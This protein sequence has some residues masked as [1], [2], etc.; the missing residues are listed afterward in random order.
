[1][2]HPDDNSAL[3]ILESGDRVPS[4]FAD[5]C[6]GGVDP[7]TGDTHKGPNV[8]AQITDADDELRRMAAESGEMLVRIDAGSLPPRWTGAY[9]GLYNATT[10]KT[11]IVRN[12]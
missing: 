8:G 2:T 4:V 5:G 11:R 3:D 6:V 12:P 7:A 10:G 9:F 1:M